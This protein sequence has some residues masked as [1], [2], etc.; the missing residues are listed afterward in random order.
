MAA[1]YNDNIRERIL[2]AAAKLLEVK[3]FAEI[4]LAEIA[5]AASISKGSIY[6]Y[7]KSKEHLLYDIA[8]AHLALMYEDLL[9]WVENSEKDTSLPRLVRYVIE[10]G[11]SGSGRNLRL[12]LTLD[13][14]SGDE[15]IRQKLLARYKLFCDK[16]GRLVFERRKIEG[17]KYSREKQEK[18]YGMLMLIL[19]DGLMIQSLLSDDGFDEHAFTE[20][21]IEMF[22]C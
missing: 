4:S 18:F 7:Y 19:I 6:Y 10:R 2:Q 14:I 1:P 5:A 11:V 16:I 12:N 21:M 22:V 20:Q 15:V 8:D 3:S 17:K 13:A 9:R